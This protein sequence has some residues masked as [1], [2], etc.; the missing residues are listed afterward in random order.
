MHHFL[1]VLQFI[2]ATV[3][4]RLPGRYPYAADMTISGLSVRVRAFDPRL[5]A[6][7]GVMEFELVP[8]LEAEW[9]NDPLVVRASRG[10]GYTPPGYAPCTREAGHSGPCAHPDPA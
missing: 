10:H 9:T 1:P 2:E 4:E 6:E 3:S 8:S 7:Y 5:A